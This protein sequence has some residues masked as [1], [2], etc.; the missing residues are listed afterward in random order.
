M[1]KPFETREEI[2]KGKG[3]FDE[4]LTD[5]I[6]VITNLRNL[7][8][9]IQDLSKLRRYSETKGMFIDDEN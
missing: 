1:I 9:L 6:L 3:R 5:V 8:L 2:E 4:I 7:F